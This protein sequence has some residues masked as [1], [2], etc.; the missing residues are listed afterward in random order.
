VENF[1]APPTK[2][3]RGIS[4][5]VPNVAGMDVSA[6]QSRIRSAG[7]TA[8]VAPQRE[9]S[10]YSAG[11]VARTDPWGGSSSA[12]GSVVTLYVSNGNPPVVTPAPTQSSNGST[13]GSSPPA[14]NPGGP[15]PRSPRFP[16]RGRGTG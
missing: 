2:L 14:T 15:E 8:Q 7:F 10:N 13:G 1:V 3:S 4:A 9:N 11:L 6:A 5:T 16:G 12:Q